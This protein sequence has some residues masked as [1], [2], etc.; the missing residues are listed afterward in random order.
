MKKLQS[1]VRPGVP[2]GRLWAH[3]DVSV[4][5]VVRKGRE[6]WQCGCS[7]RFVV[8]GSKFGLVVFSRCLNFDRPPAVAKSERRSPCI[9]PP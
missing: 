8:S 9:K 1:R 4:Y 7:K 2:L 5:V 6:R 3:S